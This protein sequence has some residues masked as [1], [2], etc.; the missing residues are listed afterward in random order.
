M[1]REPAPLSPVNKQHSFWD[2]AMQAYCVDLFGPE[3]EFMIALRR[4]ADEKGFPAIEITASDGH[5]LRLLV[6]ACGAK[7]AVEIGTLGGYSAMWI[8]R[9]LPAGGKFETFELQADRAAFAR[10]HLARAKLASEIIV[11]EGPALENLGRVKAP[12]DFV[13]IDADKSNYPAYLAWAA[14]A[15]RPGGIVALDNSFAWG[16]LRDP[17]VLG[18]RAPEADAM[19]KTLDALAHDGRFTAA[20]IPTNEGLAVG[21]RR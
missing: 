21:V 7:H 6:A 1:V 5:V 3:D 11:H 19:R 18:D 16:G 14:N 10:E 20:M 9:G 13:F 17:S 12:V 4:D 15:L 8:A 2:P